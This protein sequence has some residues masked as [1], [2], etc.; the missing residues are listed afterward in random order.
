MKVKFL[1]DLCGPNWHHKKDSIADIE[2]EE[3]SMW[4]NDSLLEPIDPFPPEYTTGQTWEEYLEET[5][6]APETVEEMNE[7][8]LASVE[9]VV[10]EEEVEVA[11]VVKPKRRTTSRKRKTSARTTTDNEPSGE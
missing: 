4:Y 11:Q 8:V 1:V 7:R 9:K 5:K 10:E 2:P 6:D 3:A